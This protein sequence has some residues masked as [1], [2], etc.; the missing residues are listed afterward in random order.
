MIIRSHPFLSCAS[1][2]QF[3]CI[4]TSSRL[5]R[6][7]ITVDGMNN[8]GSKDVPSYIEFTPNDSFAMYCMSNIE[9]EPPSCI[10]DNSFGDDAS[11]FSEEDLVVMKPRI[12][13]KMCHSPPHNMSQVYH[14]MSH[15]GDVS[16]QDLLANDETR[17]RDWFHR[18]TIP[19]FVKNDVKI[20]ST[21]KQDGIDVSTSDLEQMVLD[22]RCSSPLTFINKCA[23]S[24]CAIASSEVNESAMSSYDEQPSEVY[25][26]KV[27]QTQS[28]HSSLCPNTATKISSMIPSRSSCNTQHCLTTQTPAT[29]NYCHE[30]FDTRSRSLLMMS[31]KPKNILPRAA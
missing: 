3:P 17:H 30:C 31:P 16:Q 28:I 15:P 26:R 24:L 29:T 2:P 14:L 18:N 6:T 19:T 9:S 11:I 27:S 22:I 12:D 23:L 5:Q 25:V 7:I 13:D 4:D 8:I 10:D 21:I 1:S 20:T